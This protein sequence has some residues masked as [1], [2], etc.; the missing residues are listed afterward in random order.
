[1]KTSLELFAEID[2]LLKEVHQ[3]GIEEGQRDVF[4]TLAAGGFVQDIN[5]H[6]WYMTKDRFKEIKKKHFKHI[7]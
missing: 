3:R 7:L 1:M 4:E 6:G 2:Q 5:D